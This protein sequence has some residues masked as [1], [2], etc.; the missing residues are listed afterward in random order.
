MHPRSCARAD[1]VD[2]PGLTAAD[3]QQA[4]PGRAWQSRLERE[5]ETMLWL[6]S[7]CGGAG[8]GYLPIIHW[9]VSKREWTRDLEAR[10][11]EVYNSQPELLVKMPLELR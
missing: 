1:A 11:S 5:A 8:G 6:T 3:L 9:Y 2:P 4:E 7:G 10:H